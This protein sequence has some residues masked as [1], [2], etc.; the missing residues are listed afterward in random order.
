MSF[1]INTA[2]YGV[3]G[4]VAINKLYKMYTPR[5]PKI[6]SIEGNIGSGKSALVKSLQEAFGDKV[7]FAPEPV[8]EWMSLTDE[9]G[10]NLLELFYADKPRWS[11][12][13]QNYA[14]ISR[15]CEIQKAIKSGYRII[16]TERSI[17][18]DKN[19][20]AKMLYDEG[21]M[22]LME[23]KM[24]NKWFDNFNSIATINIYLKTSVENCNSRIAKRNR[25]GEESI[26]LDYLT[27]L[28]KYHEDWLLAPGNTSVILNGNDDFN[29]NRELHKSFIKKIKSL[30]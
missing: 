15:M 23:H 17:Q 26:S 6:L 27:K 8:D 16:I 5:K 20:F 21:D 4:V 1:Y 12:T 14:Y 13:F 2:I 22:N 28:E 30:L 10:N 3:L 25:Q 24:Y 7:Y 11:Y 19:I 29:T 9:N 18:T